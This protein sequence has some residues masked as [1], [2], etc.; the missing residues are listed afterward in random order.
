[1]TALIII[2]AVL[3]LILFT[4]LGVSAA[5]LGGELS[6]A[7]RVMF[8][9]IT[10]FPAKEKEKKKEKKPKKPKKKKPKPKKEKTEK[11]PKPELGD[12]LALAKIGLDALGSL[13]R[14]IVINDFLLHLTVADEDPYNAAVNYGRINTA[15]SML[16]PKV[17]KAF[18]IRRRD[19]KTCVDFESTELTA[20]ARLTLT[21]TVAKV[22]AVGFAAGFRFLKFKIKS[23]K[24]KSLSAAAEERWDSNGTA[25]QS[26]EKESDVGD[27]ACQHI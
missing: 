1:M 12:I 26:G 24:N 13:K 8:F 22:L 19:V 17:E 20:D 16:L 27:A 23:N 18:N 11:K 21:L 5:Y 6:L 3:A 10:V 7:V 9:N 2:L 14:K 4:P 25:N 15:L